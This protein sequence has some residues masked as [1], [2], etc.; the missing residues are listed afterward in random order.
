MLV[1]SRYIPCFRP[2]ASVVVVVGLVGIASVVMGSADFVH[3]LAGMGSIP[4][5]AAEVDHIVVVVVRRRSIGWRPL[6]GRGVYCY[7]GI[8]FVCDVVVVEM[9]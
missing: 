9:V 5:V 1:A 2:F 3:N 6:R 7:S 4:E 8:N